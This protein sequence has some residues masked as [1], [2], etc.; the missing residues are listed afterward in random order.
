M[1]LG[2]ES[3][4]LTMTL[5]SS[6]PDEDALGWLH[7]R[8]TPNLTRTHFHQLARRFG[9]P[10]YVFGAVPEQ[11]TELKGFAPEL[12][13]AVVNANTL[14]R[15]EVK[16][17]L[18][19]MDRLGVKLLSEE[20]DDYPVN[21]ANSNSPP[22]LI[23]VRGTLDKKRDQCALAVIGTRTPTQYGIT[24]TEQ[25][26]KPIA[27]RGITIV[28]GMA[29]GLDGIA[30]KATLSAKGRTIAILG[31]GLGRCYPA[32][33]KKLAETI[34]A[35]NG[36]IISEYPMETTSAFA[37]I[38]FPER[39]QVIAAMSLG[40]F[41]VEAKENSGTMITV[42]AALEENRTVFAVPGDINRE[43]SQGTN[44]LIAA[45][46]KLTQHATD[47]FDEMAEPIAR[48]LNNNTKPQQTKTMDNTISEMVLETLTREEKVI[49]D[50]LKHEPAHIDVIRDRAAPQ[51]IP[52]RIVPNI[53]MELELKELISMMPGK[54]YTTKI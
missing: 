41:V 21:L 1:V 10:A 49:L 27:A 36:A 2:E 14:M 6:E 54:I 31:T 18:E 50:I 17:E 24:I 7:I 45:G 46:A 32:S 3:G 16:K 19:R 13:R 42:K 25:L 40:V 33:H 51:G 39:N 28:S 12:A 34:I 35:E 20:D 4:R 22:P 47:I 44:A 11:I 26:V 43:N 29:I 30:H 52:P 23:Y 9:S 38:T 48:L 37:Q 8:L 53:L 5:S 15:D